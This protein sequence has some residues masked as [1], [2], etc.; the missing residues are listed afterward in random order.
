MVL[1]VNGE[2]FFVETQWGDRLSGSL[3]FLLAGG[4]FSLI[5]HF[6]AATLGDTLTL[7]PK[8]SL[9]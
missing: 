7:V 9:L 8:E 2:K 3:C 4:I 1:R 5:F 6:L